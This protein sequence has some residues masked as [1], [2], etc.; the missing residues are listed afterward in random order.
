MIDL[1]SY[2]SSEIFFSFSLNWTEF[3]REGR[4]ENFGYPFDTGWTSAGSRIASRPGKQR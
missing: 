1:L 3:D 2:A 4:K